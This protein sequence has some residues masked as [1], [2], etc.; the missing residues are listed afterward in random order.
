MEELGSL[1]VAGSTSDPDMWRSLVFLLVDRGNHFRGYLLGFRA[2]RA[3]AMEAESGN[4]LL[5][6]G[7][8]GF[9]RL[10]TGQACL[11]FVRGWGQG[12]SRFVA[13]A[14]LLA[15]GSVW[16][17]LSH[18]VLIKPQLIMGMVA[19]QAVFIFFAIFDL[20]RTM[21]SI[22]QVLHD[23]IVTIQAG[24]RMEKVFQIFV[25]FSRIWVETP[26][27]VR[28]TVLAGVLTVD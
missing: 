8:F 15:H 20:L 4:L 22:I 10:M 7:I 14:T 1:L 5:C 27:N 19:I 11:I 6:P 25:H 24:I 13:G 21:H 9:N 2:C 12:F 18:L 23:V 26:G 28:M 17:K 16:I 3:V